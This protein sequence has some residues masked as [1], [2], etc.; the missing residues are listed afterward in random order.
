MSIQFSKLPNG[1]RI[2]TD[3]TSGI[4]SLAIGIW[5]G[6]GT[7]HEKLSENGITH[8]LEHM[9]FKGTPTRT[10][11]QISDLV[12]DAG[13]HFNAYTGRETTAYYVRILN[14]HL[15]LSLDVLSDMLQNSTF[16]EDEIERERAVILQEIKM[17][18]DNP[19]D[20]VFEYAQKSAFPEQALGASGLGTPEI[21]GKISQTDL[22]KYIATHYAPER[23]VI[24]CAGDIDHDI[25]TKKVAHYFTKIPA[26]S[27]TGGDSGYCK[28]HYAPTASRIDKDTEQAHIIMGFEGLARLDPRYPAQRILSNIL[29]GGTSSRLWQEVREKHGLVYTI[30]SFQD[31]YQDGGLF[32]IYAG[33]G[34]DELEKLVPL[35]IDQIRSM[36]DSVTDQELTRAKTQITSSTRMAREKMM[37]RADQQGRYVL[38]HG[39]PFEVSPFVEK[40]NA[41][42][43]QNVI[44]LA[45]DIFARPLLLSAIGPIGKLISTEDIQNKLIS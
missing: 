31:S 24:S 12:E 45:N 38:N 3:S 11:K 2:V 23:I 28:A 5:V 26:P 36:K 35:A 1:L 27:Q 8:M 6:V 44:D 25:F 22:K 18:E 29:G 32:G 20:L 7:R 9:I 21:V 34:P 17:Y 37:T 16:P 43:A 4:D 30:Q 15:D 39:T 14:D 33:T 42:T 40:V 41:V 13:G 19:D 10:S